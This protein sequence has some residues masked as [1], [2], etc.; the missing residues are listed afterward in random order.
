MLIYLDANIVQYCADYQQFVFDNAA[1]PSFVTPRLRR[2]LVALR[3]LIELEMQIEQMDFENRWNIA[4]PS[5]LL[6]EL[7]SGRPTEDQRRVY[8]MLREAWWDCGEEKDL[9][10]T[11]DQIADIEKSLR[12]LN[13]KDAADR[14]H[15][16]EAIALGAS[17][18]L[19]NDTDIL[20]KT[21]AK[22]VTAERKLVGITPR[23]GV[24][25]GLRI[26]LPSVFLSS[27]SF[28]PV[29]GLRQLA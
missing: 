25:R 21:I 4:A 6:K 12:P 8:F 19:T 18:F 28:D 15:L 26:A 10:T 23:I 1:L 29:Y 2:E 5:H 24:V 7:F 17:W 27:L 11:E 9:A 3:R 13:L 22:A 20:K 16:A 14:W